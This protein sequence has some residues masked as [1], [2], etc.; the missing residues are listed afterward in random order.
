[1][2]RKIALDMSKFKH[3]KS[4]DKTTTL[5]HKDGH[6]LTIAHSKLTPQFQKQ[7]SA[8]AS[9]AGKSGDKAEAQ[10][11]QQ[12]GMATTPA[13]QAPGKQMFAGGGAVE[14][15]SG[16]HKFKVQ[17]TAGQASAGYELQHTKGKEATTYK[18]FKNEDEAKNHAKGLS[19]DASESY[20][21]GG[22]VQRF[23][24]GGMSN[25]VNSDEGVMDT[26]KDQYNKASSNLQQAFSSPQP[27]P[28]PSSDYGYG[29][30]KYA[31]GGEVDQS[32]DTPAPPAALAPANPGNA[33]PIKDVTQ[34]DLPS[35]V[36]REAVAKD[37]ANQQGQQAQTQSNMDVY[38][39]MRQMAGGAT[40]ADLFGPNGQPPS[41]PVSPELWSQAKIAPDDLRGLVNQ[42]KSQQ[43][44]PALAQQQD[45]H[46]KLVAQNATNQELGL[47]LLPD[48]GAPQ[49]DPQA[50]AK[51]DAAADVSAV[52]PGSQTAPTPQSNKP[53]LNMDPM[54]LFQQGYA[55][56]RAGIQNEASAI[57]QQ[58]TAN[59][60]VLQQ[61]A[62]AKQKALTGFQQSY[63]DMN[64]ERLNVKHDIENGYIDP[65][66]YWKGVKNPATGEMEGGH[67]K[68]MAGIGMLLGGMNSGISGG[69]NQAMQMLQYNMDKNIEAQSKN[70][71]AK[72]NLLGHTINQFGN[73]RAGVEMA[74]MMNNDMLDYQ[75]KKQAAL[76]AS[77]LAQA[78]AQ[79]ATGE[80]ESSQSDKA[81]SLAMMHSMMSFNQGNEV[82]GVL[83]QKLQMLDVVNPEFAKMQRE[84]MVG[85]IGP[86]G[87]SVISTTSSVPDSVKQQ[88]LGHK[89]MNDVF[90]RLQQF[91]SQHQTVLSKLDP[92]SRSEA[93]TLMAEAQSAVRTSEDQ[94]VFKK[95]D[96][97]FL[98]GE[99]GKGPV[100]LLS[101]INS[102]PK[103]KALQSI[104]AQRY[105]E[106]A[107]TY[108]LKGAAPL[109]QFQDNSPVKGRDGRMYTTHVSP[110]GQRY[111][112]PV[113]S[114]QGK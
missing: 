1:M 26:L 28:K 33:D 16:P 62:D 94:G 85:G 47:P 64:Q 44:A 75:I 48:P 99:I 111:M 66:Q 71:Q 104:N 57:G 110:S 8:L 89:N 76:S 106:T 65:Q 49:A 79:K 100:S 51:S 59:A 78:A 54:H 6:T 92:K 12:Q 45:E 108:G 11:D 5:Q 90:N 27:T 14:W 101:K 25:A 105:G 112:L 87:A 52:Q 30:A 29:A 2:S 55:D 97:D 23:A 84:R 93:D 56:Q 70:L 39:H 58:G 63:N 109:E 83:E 91:A 35:M 80:L 9:M 38:N 73:V 13:T 102:D 95:S 31:D 18:G 37:L 74:R 107:K 68:I 21:R 3:I 15:A 82:P 22:Q 7:L 67:S 32:Q 4:D 86:N 69:P 10:E 24:D 41:N 43:Q 61:A 98:Q 77:P 88:L 46:N 19:T 50:Q 96:S 36:K 40:P 20:A 72:D 17:R 103:I 60:G 34:V 81:R 114:Q 42:F 53:G 113:T